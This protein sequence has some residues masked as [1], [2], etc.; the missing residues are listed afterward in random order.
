MAITAGGRAVKLMLLAGLTS[1]AFE[2][3]VEGT[4]QGQCFA[5]CG[6]VETACKQA[7]KFVC[8]T[9]TWDYG[10]KQC[11]TPSCC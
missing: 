5:A 7:G 4:S 8:G 3:G 6:H 11:T 9:C 1:I 10:A 2:V